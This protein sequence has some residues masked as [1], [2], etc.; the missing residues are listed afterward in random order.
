ML[1]ARCERLRHNQTWVSK[2]ITLPSTLWLPYSLIHYIFE[3]SLHTSFWGHFCYSRVGPAGARATARGRGSRS[4]PPGRPQEA[5]GAAAPHQGDRK[6]R[7]Y[8]IRDGLPRRCI[9]GAIKPADHF[10]VNPLTLSLLRG[11]FSLA[12]ETTRYRNLTRRERD[13]HGDDQRGVRRV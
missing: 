5:G 12:M 1:K 8:H 11:I 7:P 10:S 6:G 9:V 3:I 4:T 13:K 2:I